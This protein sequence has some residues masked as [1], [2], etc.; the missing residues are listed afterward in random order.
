MRLTHT[1]VGLR[2]GGAMQATGH[3]YTICYTNQYP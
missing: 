3:M 2:R 1:R